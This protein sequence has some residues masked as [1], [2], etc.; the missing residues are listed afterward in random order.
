MSFTKPGPVGRRASADDGKGFARRAGGRPDRLAANPLDMP[1][2]R[3]GGGF[4]VSLPQG[5][6]YRPVVLICPRLPLRAP[7]REQ[8]AGTGG[9]QVVDG[10][11]Q[12]RHAAW[13]QDQPV[14]GTV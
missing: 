14:K 9:V 3:R 4:G 7:C 5:G 12:A 6:Q 2:K 13:R 8:E 10:G 11:E 1:P